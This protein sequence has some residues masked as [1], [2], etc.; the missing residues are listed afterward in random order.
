MNFVLRKGPKRS[1]T[2]SKYLNVSEMGQRSN[3]NF[4]CIR[5]VQLSLVSVWLGEKNLKELAVMENIVLFTDYSRFIQ[6]QIRDAFI[7][8][9]IHSCVTTWMKASQPCLQKVWNCSCLLTI[10]TR[11]SEVEEMRHVQEYKCPGP[12]LMVPWC[13]QW[14]HEVFANN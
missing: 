5:L 4:Q 6:T 11:Q 9:V 12:G 1:K 7:Q 14:C 2:V 8:V 13:D 3:P 10:K